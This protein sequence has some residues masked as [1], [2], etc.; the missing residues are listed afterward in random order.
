M[1]QFYT[2]VQNHAVTISAVVLILAYIFI[3]L[4]KIPKVTI[5]LLGAAVVVFS[6]LVSQEKIAETGI[7]ELYFINFVDFNVIFLLVSMMIIVNITTR[8]GVFKWMAI[9]LLKMTK[10]KPLMV[11]LLSFLIVL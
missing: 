5:A 4:E 10:G 9:E 1:E 2:L 8:C 6:G 7:N 11:F 3:A